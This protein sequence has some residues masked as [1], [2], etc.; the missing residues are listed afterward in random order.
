MV[1]EINMSP[2]KEFPKFS[3]DKESGEIAIFLEPRDQ[4]VPIYDDGADI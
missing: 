4:K 1:E 2:L 3:K